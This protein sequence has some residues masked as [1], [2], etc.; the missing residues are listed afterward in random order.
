[1]NIG[2][3]NWELSKDTGLY[4]FNPYVT[5]YHRATDSHDRFS[6]VPSIFGDTGHDLRETTF[7]QSVEVN[8]VVFI[9]ITVEVLTMASL[10][11][12]SE[13]Q[14]MVQ[15]YF[16]ET[17]YNELECKLQATLSKLNFIKNFFFFVF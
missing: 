2:R 12:G 4:T 11:S 10:P 3:I 16:R 5:L 14:Q 17:M 15:S 9:Q 1:L 6:E 8:G 13:Q 7:F